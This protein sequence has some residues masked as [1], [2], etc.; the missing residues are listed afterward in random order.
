MRLRRQWTAGGTEALASAG[1]GA[2]I[3]FQDE[4]G[5]VLRPPVAKTWARRGHTPVIEVSGKGSGRV[6]IAGLVCLKPGQ[7]GRLM[8]R[9]RLHRSRKGERGSFSEDDYIAFLDQAHQ[10]L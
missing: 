10:C 6:S 2:W 4:A 1:P 8:W 7:K 3:C 5:Q 9:T